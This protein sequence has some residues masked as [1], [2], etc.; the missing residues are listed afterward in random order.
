MLIL[1]RISSHFEHSE[2]SPAN[3]TRFTPFS[4]EKLPLVEMTK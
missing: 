1:P 2:K 4:R 3:K